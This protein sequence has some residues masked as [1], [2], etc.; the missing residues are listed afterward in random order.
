VTAPEVV[1]ERMPDI[2]I[3]SWCGKKFRPEKGGRSARLQSDAGRAEGRNPRDQIPVDPPTG[4]GGM[5]VSQFEI[6]G[7]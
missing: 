7:A 3:G 6:R 2:I 1:V 5:A 4:S